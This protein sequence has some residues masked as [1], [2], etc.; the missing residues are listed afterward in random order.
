MKYNRP[1]GLSRE[2]NFT[3]FCLFILRLTTCYQLQ[4]FL[5][6]L[7]HWFVVFLQAV[8]VIQFSPFSKTLDLAGVVLQV[9]EVRH[10]KPQYIQD[11]GDDVK[12]VE[13]HLSQQDNTVVMVVGLCT[14][15]I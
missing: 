11:T 6:L 5:L 14:T 12:D 8:P 3:F 13:T 4:K 1:V 15:E 10:T 7:F 9:I 2:P